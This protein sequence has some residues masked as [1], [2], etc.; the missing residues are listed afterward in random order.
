MP[1]VMDVDSGRFFLL[2]QLRPTSK[3]TVSERVQEMSYG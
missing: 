1:M 3:V 2:K